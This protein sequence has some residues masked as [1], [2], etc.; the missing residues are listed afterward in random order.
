MS[1]FA[2][3]REMIDVNNPQ[4]M[5]IDV[6]SFFMLSIDLPLLLGALMRPDNR[7]V[8][9]RDLEDF[10]DWVHVIQTRLLLES[11]RVKLLLRESQRRLKS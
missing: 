2:D 10:H 9:I 8:R 1:E 11:L 7:S 6:A 5:D 4:F 3:D